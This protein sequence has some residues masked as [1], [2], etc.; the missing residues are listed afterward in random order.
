[1]F[2]L[3][4]MLSCINDSVNVFTFAG[5]NNTKLSINKD[6][7]NVKGNSVEF[8]NFINTSF[9]LIGSAENCLEPRN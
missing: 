3:V 2:V 1:M 8:D 7:N 4:E 9:K 6:I 5:V